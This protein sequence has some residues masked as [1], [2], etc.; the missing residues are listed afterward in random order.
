MGEI[1]VQDQVCCGA[2]CMSQGRPGPSV[3]CVP[4]LR[5][6]DSLTPFFMLMMK[7]PCSSQQILLPSVQLHPLLFLTALHFHAFLLLLGGGCSMFS[8]VLLRSVE[9]TMSGSYEAQ[10]TI[11]F[12]SPLTR[13]PLAS[14]SDLLVRPRVSTEFERNGRL[15]GSR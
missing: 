6:E 15:E 4:T 10:S 9:S 8:S 14:V 5:V 1:C 7:C 12:S 3:M 13:P 2:G 11:L